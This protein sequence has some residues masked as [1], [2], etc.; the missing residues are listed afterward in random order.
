LSRVGLMG[1]TFDPIH[2]GHL[3]TAEEAYVRFNL[4]KVIF[5]PSGNPPHKSAKKVTDGFDRFIMT[6]MATITNPHFEVSRIEVDADGPTYTVD[7]LKALKEDGLKDAEL[8]FITGADAIIEICTWKN[9]RE[10]FSLCRFAAATR[11]GY[12]ISKDLVE[13][14]AQFGADRLDFFE[15]P[16]LA[17]SSTD[18][19]CRIK[20][21]RPVRYLLPDEVIS[22]IAKNGLYI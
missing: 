6:Q 21:A 2:Y 5:I 12:V 3:V 13:S 8:I 10:L 15:V 1:G 19:R 7:T 16:A 9:P 14:V 22:Y 18:I 17:I 4:D 11:P 20:E